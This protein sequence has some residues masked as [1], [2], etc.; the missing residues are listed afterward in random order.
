MPKTCWQNCFSGIL[1]FNVVEQKKVSWQNWS[2]KLNVS[3]VACCARLL[4]SVWLY[5][6]DEMQLTHKQSQIFVCGLA[7]I[8]NSV[9]WM[10][11][12][13]LPDISTRKLTKAKAATNQQAIFL[14]M[15]LSSVCLS[16][17]AALLRLQSALLPAAPIEHSLSRFTAH[18]ANPKGFET[19]PRNSAKIV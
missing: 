5:K 3:I 18:Q 17:S 1:S 8:W 11:L 7:F 16:V 19:I 10:H 9:I 2:L 4:S 15:L 13:T 12:M 6:E 14:S